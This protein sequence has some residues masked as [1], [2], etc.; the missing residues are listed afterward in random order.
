[1]ATSRTQS[2]LFSMRQWVAHKSTDLD[3]SGVLGGEAGDSQ[4]SDGAGVPTGMV[5]DVAFDQ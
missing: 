4:D 3:R 5:G 1:M 2:S